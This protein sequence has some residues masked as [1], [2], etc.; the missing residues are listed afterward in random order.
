MAPTQQIHHSSGNAKHFL[1]DIQNPWEE[2][3]M[4]E[5]WLVG[6]R[7]TV[8][9]KVQLLQLRFNEIGI[10][11]FY[12]LRCLQIRQQDQSHYQLLDKE[13]VHH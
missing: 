6:N 2:G 12:F 4:R 3:L 8:Q 9:S 13:F 7:T 1:V 5:G 11:L 10:M